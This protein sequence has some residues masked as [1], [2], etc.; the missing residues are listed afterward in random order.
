MAE[1]INTKTKFWLWLC[2]LAYR[3]MK[4]SQN[5]LP[6]GIPGMRDPDN[7]CEAYTPRK[8]P[9]SEPSAICETDGHYL[10][11]ECAFKIH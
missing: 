6:V 9:I 7:K 3:K 2:R 8:K 1:S 10:C 5:K 4:I 11:I